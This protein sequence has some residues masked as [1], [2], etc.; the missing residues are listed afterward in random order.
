[1]YINFIFWSLIN[2]RCYKGIK[3]RTSK[4]VDRWGI[5]LIIFCLT[6]KWT[7]LWRSAV[8]KTNKMLVQMHSMK[9]IKRWLSNK[10]RMNCMGSFSLWARPFCLAHVSVLCCFYFKLCLHFGYLNVLAVPQPVPASR[11]RPRKVLGSVFRIPPEL[12]IS[13]LLE[14]IGWV[15]GKCKRKWLMWG[16]CLRVLDHWWLLVDTEC[17]FPPSRIADEELVLTHSAIETADYA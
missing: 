16:C 13:I 15:V 2:N 9:C 8:L 7:A 14:F 1:M 4:S 17:A 11:G 3:I 5:I 6:I 10:N 12:D